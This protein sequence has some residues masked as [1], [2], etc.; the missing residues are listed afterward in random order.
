MENKGFSLAWGSNL[1]PPER[2]SSTLPVDQSLNSMLI[3]TKPMQTSKSK[4]WVELLSQVRVW[5]KSSFFELFQIWKLVQ[6]SIFELNF[7]RKSS[8]LV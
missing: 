8:I 2:E 5:D 1:D 3:K 6:G 4:F 7:G